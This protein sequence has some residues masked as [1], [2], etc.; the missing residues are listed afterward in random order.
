M[1]EPF[2]RGTDT[3][4]TRRL[5]APCAPRRPRAYSAC[6]VSVSVSEYR[7]ARVVERFRLN[8]FHEYTSQSRNRSRR[9]PRVLSG[10][11][12]RGPFTILG[13]ATMLTR[14]SVL[15]A[16]RSTNPY[17]SLASLVREEFKL[18]SSFNNVATDYWRAFVSLCE[19]PTVSADILRSVSEVWDWLQLARPNV[20]R[21]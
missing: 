13:D 16:A 1:P 6:W 5:V 9:A 11:D 21:L 12:N 17:R 8:K 10:R 2:S 20:P 15:N 7:T 18:G 14:E 3:A 4:A 19:T